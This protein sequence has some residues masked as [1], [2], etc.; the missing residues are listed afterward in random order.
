MPPHVLTTRKF[1]YVTF[2]LF[3]PPDLQ[4]SVSHS[5]TALFV[6]QFPAYLCGVARH[7]TIMLV[8]ASRPPTY[9]ALPS[10]SPPSLPALKHFTPSPPHLSPH[11][12]REETLAERG[13]GV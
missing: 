6:N 7:E 3:S 12:A 5:S 8:L 11:V 13:G 1:I 9:P 4:A 10:V 2:S